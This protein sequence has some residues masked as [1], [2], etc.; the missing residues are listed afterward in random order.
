MPVFQHNI[1]FSYFYTQNKLLIHSCL[2]NVREVFSVKQ[3]RKNSKFSC[4]LSTM[5]NVY[6]IFT[7]RKDSFT[8]LICDE[9]SP[10]QTAYGPCTLLY[11]QSLTRR[12]E[13][14][15]WNP[16]SKP[17]SSSHAVNITQMTHRKRAMN[18]DDSCQLFV[19]LR[20]T[21]C[22]GDVLS[23]VSISNPP[24]TWRWKQWDS[25]SPPAWS[26]RGRP[27]EKKKREVLGKSEMSNVSTPR[28]KSRGNA[29][30]VAA[31]RKSWTSLDVSFK[32]STFYLA[33]TVF[34]LRD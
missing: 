14:R 28:K 25:C 22:L 3:R 20:R 6:E 12:R 27:G 10:C 9:F 21:A 29:W 15:A 2:Q 17:P 34:Y 31:E 23:R 4:Y 33:S 32:L 1:E 16:I 13:F 11:K 19:I 18:S 30:N 24:I 8:R 5:L 26:Q 7:F